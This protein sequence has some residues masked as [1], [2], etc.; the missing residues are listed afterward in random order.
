MLPLP[1]LHQPGVARG[2][3]PL[4]GHDQGQNPSLS[5]V[6]DL[7]KFLEIG[8]GVTLGHL[9]DE[10]M[11][12]YMCWIH[13]VACILVTL[14]YTDLHVR[15][16]VVHQDVGLRPEDARATGL[17]KEEGMFVQLNLPL[18]SQFILNN[19]RSRSRSRSPPR[20]RRPSRR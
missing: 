11:Y 20:R 8:G 7:P 16:E 5:R 15:A 12:M 19:Y 17:L 4:Q 14:M 13:Y 18:F 10:G 6:L 1:P 9:G 2:Q 3:S